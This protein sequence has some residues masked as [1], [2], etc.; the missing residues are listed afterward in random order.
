MSNMKVVH[1][2]TEE[3]VTVR[4]VQHHFASVLQKIEQGGEI[5][6]IKRGK[7]VARMISIPSTEA[8]SK[9]PDWDAFFRCKKEFWGSSQFGENAILQEREGNER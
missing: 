1:K 4:E 5:T 6:I 7:P 2:K 8:E 3:F 9:R